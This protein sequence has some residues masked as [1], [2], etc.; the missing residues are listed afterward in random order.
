MCFYRIE[1][2]NTHG[3]RILHSYL[4]ARFLHGP[5]FIDATAGGLEEGLKHESWIMCDSLVSLRNADL[6]NFVGSLSASRLTELDR[7]VKMALELE[8]ACDCR[9]PAASNNCCLSLIDYAVEDWS[10]LHFPICF[11]HR[12]SSYCPEHWNPFTPIKHVSQKHQPALP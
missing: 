6:S 4:R 8:L 5:R 10:L 3:L 2:A 9:S 7:A 11:Q 12:D 1:T